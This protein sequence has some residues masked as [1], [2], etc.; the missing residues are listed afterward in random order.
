MTQ[1]DSN[2]CIRTDRGESGPGLIARS[3]EGETAWS[4][5]LRSE[6]CSVGVHLSR[7]SPDGP[8][9]MVDVHQ[10]QGY[11][12]RDKT[13]QNR[14]K[15]GLYKVQT[16][17]SLTCRTA[18]LSLDLLIPRTALIRDHSETETKELEHH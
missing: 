2:Y 18:L 8:Q 1:F 16:R 14:T 5:D 4:L 12:E 7:T 11:E 6:L 13:G 10:W 9:G 15:P 3:E 17:S